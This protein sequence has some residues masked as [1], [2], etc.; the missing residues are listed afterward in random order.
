[1]A[2]RA[3]I[4]IDLG[5]TT[6]QY[7]LL[8][9]GQ[10]KPIHC[11]SFHTEKGR[12]AILEQFAQIVTGLGV[13]AR[14]LGCRLAGAGVGSAGI[15][16]PES[17][18]IVGRSPNIPGWEGTEVKRELEAR[19]GVQTWVDND[20]NV[21]AL[22]E[23]RLGA[24]R[25]FSSGLYITV[26]T[27]IGSGIVLDGRLWRGAAFAGAEMGHMIIAKEGRA[28]GCGKRGCLEV[29]A[30]AGAFVRYYDKS[31]PQSSPVKEIFGRA[32][33]GDSVAQAA[34][35]QA[36]GYLA[37]G[38][39]SVLELLN[40]EIVVIGGGISA[41]TGYLAEVRRCLPAY[42]TRPALQSVKLRKAKLG[43]RAGL[44]GAAL[45][46]SET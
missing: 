14:Q 17:G 40:P 46:A 27:G 41:G 4:G 34:I 12:L 25:G 28:C 5:G 23:H 26:G 10:D 2:K 30:S 20:A 15:V 16:N 3:Y 35:H 9:A 29:Y 32:R 6:I 7:G 39:G 38:I 8:I 37:C 44:I 42:V 33:Q 22:A 45:L 19:T 1:M 21:M 43:N 36:A 24:G 11:S 13:K 31:L 18:R